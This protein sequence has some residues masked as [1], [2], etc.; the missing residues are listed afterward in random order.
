[1][2]EAWV[3]PAHVYVRI[4]NVNLQHNAQD[5]GSINTWEQDGRV[6]IPRSGTV[7]LL[8]TIASKAALEPT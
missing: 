3:F 1:V 5:L 7:I 2:Q 6:S 8:S 4:E